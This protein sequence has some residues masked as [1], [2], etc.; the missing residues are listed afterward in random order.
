VVVKGKGCRLE[1]HGWGPEDLLYKV[2]EGRCKRASDLVSW[3][4]YELLAHMDYTV[5]HL[6]WAPV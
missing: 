6:E 3:I 2:S 1:W 4:N 5:R